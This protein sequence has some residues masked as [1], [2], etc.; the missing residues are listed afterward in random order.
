MM[1]PYHLN[2]LL[3]GAGPSEEELLGLAL[4]YTSTSQIPNTH[5]LPPPP[6]SSPPPPNLAFGVSPSILC[7]YGHG[8]LN[9]SRVL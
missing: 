6:P 4:R 3:G 2:T 7:T 8:A 9:T 1:Q 5:P